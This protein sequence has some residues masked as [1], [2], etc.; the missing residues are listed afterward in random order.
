[1]VSRNPSNH[2]CSPSHKLAA[3]QQEQRKEQLD[4]EGLQS[5]IDSLRK[6]YETELSQWETRNEKLEEEL[7]ETLDLLD[8]MKIEDGKHKEIQSDLAQQ[9]CNK[10]QEMEKADIRRTAQQNDLQDL[11][12]ELEAE[13]DSARHSE[14]DLLE[15]MDEKEKKIEGLE[16]HIVWVR[17]I[18]ISLVS[19]T[20]IHP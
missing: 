9:L 13:R 8:Q 5:E 2:F 10:Q 12:K 18:L 14:K 1:M 11:V 19:F 20:F 3:I 6:K 16:V 17:S 15:E 4:T 7:S